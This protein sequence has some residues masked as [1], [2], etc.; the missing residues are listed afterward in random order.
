MLK[1]EK[2]HDYFVI[3][4]PLGK[5]LLLKL[6]LWP[7]QQFEFDMPALVCVPIN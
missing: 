4:G 1:I 7:A 3:C 5:F 6:I 2:N